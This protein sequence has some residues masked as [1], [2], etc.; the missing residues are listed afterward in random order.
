MSS[1]IYHTAD[2]VV[3]MSRLMQERGIPVVLNSFPRKEVRRLQLR[4]PAIAGNSEIAGRIRFLAETQGPP[5]KRLRFQIFSAPS[6]SLREITLSALFYRSFSP[7]VLDKGEDYGFGVSSVR[8]TPLNWA[9]GVPIGMSSAIYHTATVEL[10]SRLMKERGL[11]VVRTSFHGKKS[12]DY[13]FGGPPS[14]ETPKIAGRIRFLA[15]TQGP[16]RKRL[17]FQIFSASSVPLREIT[18]SALFY[19][20]FSPT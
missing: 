6:A 17:R 4:R 9:E 2:T 19:R 20:S 7:N 16:P 1:A 8:M 11:P 10:M 14:P 5:R 18:L 13:N 3:L 15:E 12:G